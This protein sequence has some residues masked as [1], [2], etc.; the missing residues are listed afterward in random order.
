MILKIKPMTV[1][2][3]WQGRRYKTEKYKKWRQNVTYLL[4][5]LNVPNVKLKVMLE[6][7]FSNK[8]S[9]IDNPIKCILDAIQFKYG[10]N[11]KMIYRLEVDKQIV[12][13]GDEYIKFNIE[14]L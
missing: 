8:S 4:P 13:K 3:A 9:D 2:E 12:K 6:F 10:F 11:D 14:E 7:G 1:N 5:T